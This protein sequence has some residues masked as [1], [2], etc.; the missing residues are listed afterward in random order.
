[1]ESNYWRSFDTR[2]RKLTGKPGDLIIF[3][4]NHTHLHGMNTSGKTRKVFIIESQTK[5]DIE[6]GYNTKLSMKLA[7]KNI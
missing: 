1:M 7:P 2:T 6:Y 5:K 3:D 4:S